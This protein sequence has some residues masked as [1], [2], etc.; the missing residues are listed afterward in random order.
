MQEKRSCCTRP[1]GKSA[2]TGPPT[3]V[4][5]LRCR[6]SD[7]VEEPRVLSLDGDL[8]LDLLETAFLER[9]Q[10]SMGA[11]SRTRRRRPERLEVFVTPSPGPGNKRELSTDCG[12]W[13]RW[14]ARRSEIFYLAPDHTL[15]AVAVDGEEPVRGTRRAAV[16]AAKPR[17]SQAQ[18]AY[19]YDVWADGQRFLVSTYRL[20]LSM[21]RCAVKLVVNLAGATRKIDVMR[22]A[23]AVA[24]RGT[25][26]CRATD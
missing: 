11:G 7:R 6:R 18:R 20:D 1:S 4:P 19:P 13:A 14:R 9:G 15:V 25:M 17:L 10:F 2:T 8:R 3:A 24:A 22:M 5:G 16:V 21:G 12:G 23:A 26:R